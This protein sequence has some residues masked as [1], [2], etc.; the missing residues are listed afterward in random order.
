[1]K[2]KASAVWR[3]QGLTGTGNLTTPSGVLNDTPYSAKMR[4]EDQEGRSGTNPEELIAAAHAGC[5]SMA[6]AFGLGGAGFTPE[7]ISTDAELTME[8]GDAGWSIASIH[9]KLRARV[10]GISNDEFQKAAAG[11][12]EGCPVSKVLRANITLDATLL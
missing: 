2:R 12:K 3:G 6:L 8:K 10:P 5:Y 9:L 1:M 11:A 7:E 4:F